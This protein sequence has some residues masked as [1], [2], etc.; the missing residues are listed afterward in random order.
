MWKENN[1]CD[2]CIC[3]GGK[4]QCVPK[5]CDI[6]TCSPGEKLM[7]LDDECCG[8]CVPDDESCTDAAGK[9][10]SVSNCFEHCYKTF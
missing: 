4:V 3:I 8:Q 7:K 2:D 9:L 6:L 5:S 1:G 10:H